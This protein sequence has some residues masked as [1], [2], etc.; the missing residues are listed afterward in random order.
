[1]HLEH[2][3]ENL[4]YLLELLI[5]KCICFIGF[6]YFSNQIPYYGALVDLSIGVVQVGFEFEN[7]ESGYFRVTMLRFDFRS[8]LWRFCT[9]RSIQRVMNT[10]YW[11]FLSKKD[12]A[13]L[14]YLSKVLLFHDILKKKKY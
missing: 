8:S 14:I 7:F 6:V 10:I 3:L 4:M 5:N 1:M 12:F 13:F 9:V 2:M 11:N